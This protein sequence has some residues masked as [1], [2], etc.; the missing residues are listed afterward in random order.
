MTDRRVEAH[1]ER[2]LVAAVLVEAW[3]DLH[4]GPFSSS[5]GPS[6]PR[7]RESAAAWIGSDSEA[8]WSYRWAARI[9]GY[10]PDLLARRMATRRPAKRGRRAPKRRGRS[11]WIA[12]GAPTP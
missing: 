11:P 2:R 4:G 5:W 6:R 9:L 7:L 1:G 12:T 10:Q 8:P 3:R